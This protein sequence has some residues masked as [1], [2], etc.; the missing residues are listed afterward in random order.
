MEIRIEIDERIERPRVIIEA[1]KMT[2]EI[3]EIIQRIQ[4]VRPEALAGFREDAAEILDPDEIIRIATDGGR[5]YAY[6]V[7]GRFLLKM[8]LYEVKNRLDPEV[9][10]P[11]SQSEIIN[12]RRVRRFD[13]SRTGVIR[14]YF[15]DG[16]STYVSR[17]YMAAIR[18][19]LGLKK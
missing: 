7:Q 15:T 2:A 16:D 19:L 1:P 17:R 4:N 12:L 6:T 13:L 8:R 18:R 14:I 3:E 5:L 11:V 10:V 9:F